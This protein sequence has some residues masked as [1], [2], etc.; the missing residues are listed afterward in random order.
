MTH[1][2]FLLAIF[3]I[4]APPQ[5]RSS[6]A[7]RIEIDKSDRQMRVFRGSTQIHR[8]PVAL[9]FSAEGDKSIEGDGRTPTGSFHIVTRNPQSAYYR[10][11]GLSYPTSEDAAR[12]LKQGL[13][14]PGQAQAIQE[15]EKD[16]RQPPWNTPLGGAIGIHGRGALGD[17]TLGCIAVE[18]TH[19]KILWDLGRL[20]LQVNIQE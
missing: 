10:F 6:E 14:G 12:G 15:A 20:G 4:L 18:D 11:L 5:S 3:L 2:S 9:G 1:A 7:I 16:E 8:F 19:M 13:I 17:W